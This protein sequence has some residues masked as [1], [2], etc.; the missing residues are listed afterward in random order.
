MVD[1]LRVIAVIAAERL[2]H[3]HAPN[4]HGIAA[5]ARHAVA[6]I[7]LLGL[8]FCSALSGLSLSFD[9]IPDLTVS[10]D[11]KE[12]CATDKISHERR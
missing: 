11:R 10:Q 9:L 2:P 8:D 1:K 7:P 12:P 6:D 5:R 3:S 4:R